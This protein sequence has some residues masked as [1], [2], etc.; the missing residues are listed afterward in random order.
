MKRRKLLLS[1]FMISLVSC[2][3]KPDVDA[4]LNYPDVEK[5][6]CSGHQGQEAYSV[7][8]VDFLRLKKNEGGVFFT[9]EEWKLLVDYC[10]QVHQ[11]A[12]STCMMVN[13]RL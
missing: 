3:E 12:L 2:K 11:E 5:F 8:W 1:L 9:A 10:K 7:P 4:C 13:R 6:Y